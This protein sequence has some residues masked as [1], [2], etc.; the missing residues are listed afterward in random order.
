MKLYRLTRKQ[1]LPIS[2]EEAWP[3][4]S[5]PHNLEQI[6]PAFLRFH[7][8]SPVPDEIYNGLIITYRIAAIAGIPLTWVTE[9]KHVEPFSQFV[10]EQRLGPYRFWH[11]L[12]RFREV[13]GGVEMEDIVH[14]VMP[15]GWLGRLAHVVFVQ[16]RLKAI[17]DFRRDYL[18]GYFAARRG[19]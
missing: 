3:F 2:L 18:A 17:F 15:F 14:Y 10:D 19:L 9:I 8:T 16:D 13:E 7:I 1:T 5:T 12:H 11:H 4:F 6:T